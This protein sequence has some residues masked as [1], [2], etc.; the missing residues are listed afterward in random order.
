MNSFRHILTLYI[1]LILKVGFTQNPTNLNVN[2]ISSS[3]AILSWD[4]GSCLDLKL[5]IKKDI[6]NNWQDSITFGITNIG[7]SESHL[8]SFLDDNTTYNWQVF[9]NN[10]WI[11]G[12]NFITLCNKN[13][14]QTISAFNPDPIFG[15]MQFSYDTLTIVNTANCDINIRPEF[16][17]SH[18]DSNIEIGD[19]TIEWY[20]PFIG[21]WPN[22]PYSVDNNGNAFGFW[23]T[24][25]TDTTGIN[26]S[27]GTTQQMIIRVRFMNPNNNPNSTPTPFG[28][29][30]AVWKTYEVDQAGNIIQTLA[31]ED[32]VSL[33]LI[34]CS[35]FSTS[36][37]F[38][39][40]TCFGLNNGS[41]SI[42]SIAFGSGN[43]SYSWS[44]GETTSSID[45]LS[46]GNYF[47]NIVDLN[48]NCAES[49]NFTISEPS[50][51][52]SNFTTTDVSCYDAD[53]GAASVNFFGGTPGSL[54]GDT[55]NYILGWDTLLYYLPTP[56]TV[57]NTPIGVPAGIYP[58]SVT[59]QNGCVHR[60]TINI[61]QP[62]ELSATFSLSNFNG[63]NIDCFNNN[64]GSISIQISG[65]TAPYLNYLN[66]NLTNNVINNL[67]SS[68]YIDSIIDHNGCTF[69]DTIILTQPD[70]LSIDFTF[71]SISCYG[72]CD[73]TINSIITS[74]GSIGP[75][76]NPNG[77]YLFQWGHLSNLNIPV[78]YNVCGETQYT[79][80][81][82]D[83]NN[84]SVTK[85]ITTVQ[86]DSIYYS[87]DSLI[88]VSTY[89][90][91]DGLINISTY[92]GSGSLSTNWSAQNNFTSNNNNISS[93]FSDVYY[94]TISDL[95]GCSINDSISISQPSSLSITISNN[96]NISCHGLCDGFIDIFPD[97][98]D[99]TYTFLWTGP[100]GFTSTN[101]DITGLCYGAYIIALSDTTTTIY[102]TIFISEPLELFSFI[103]ADSLI[104]NGDS[105]LATILVYGGTSPF[106][107]TWS[108]G[109]TNYNNYINFG[110]NTVEVVDANGCSMIDSIVINNPDPIILQTTSSNISCFGLQDGIVSININSGGTQPF[111]YSS[112]NGA[113]FQISNTFFNVDAGNNNFIVIDS[114]SCS[115]S[116]N[117]LINEPDSMYNNI[118]KTDVSCYSLCD[119]SAIVTTFGGT[120]PYTTN[121]GSANNMSLCAGYYN[122]IVSDTNGCIIADNIIINE[123][124]P[125][126]INITQNGNFLQVSS[127]Y[128]NYQWYDSNNNPISGANSNIF[129][130]N[131]NGIYFVEV[132]DSNGCSSNSTEFL[133]SY[134]NSININSKIKIYPNPTSGQININHNKG[135]FKIKI[136]NSLGQTIFNDSDSL[137]KNNGISYDFSS[138]KKGIYYLKFETK[139]EIF[140]QSIILQ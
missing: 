40:I 62:Q 67:S 16:I 17:I 5:R 124:N 93:L 36:T 20:N 61:Y 100:N 46:A 21:N 114:N 92:G 123:P 44:N 72:Q 77:N 94:L 108:D 71:S 4:N 23:S 121:W 103:S 137:I 116:I 13:V 73:G 51:L 105:T 95:N 2:S 127:G 31:P 64:T 85:S 112:N 83:Y 84:C 58:Y 45:N 59:D 81:V 25:A 110:N 97:G 11:D 39:D 79:L 10:Q 49:I 134:N 129:Y 15:Y 19:F 28:T 80:T 56:L 50:N 128:S 126:I 48:Y 111:S 101:E 34:N 38:S 113:N 132:I 8:V 118:F 43:Y 7:T 102:D 106:Q 138:L 63:Y 78:A 70:S 32:S 54:T 14:T 136:L 133:F 74:P 37:S 6:Q 107:Y 26:L 33:S 87:I 24:S 60:D 109:G 115:T 130:P 35:L 99:S 120:P 65:G 69:I 42:N 68:I 125:I 12:P 9:C 117:V 140:M 96:S 1:F 18:A 66:N 55:I 27:V 131:I 135:F 76:N 91:N 86:P 90:G 104:C 122:I 98:G 29:Y 139:D 89:G 52:T 47:C 22:I 41:A 82:T 3:S 30:T 75:P 53:D 88:N 119:G 57:F